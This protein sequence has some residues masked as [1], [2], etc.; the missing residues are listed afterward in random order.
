VSTHRSVWLATA[1]QPS[2]PPLDRHV[3]VDVVVV[4]GGITGL[5]TALFAQREGARVAVVE[6]DRIGGGTT[7]HTTGKVTSQHS[8]TYHGLIEKH[9][10]HRARLYAEANEAA[11]GMV[12]ALAE[13]TGADCQFERVPSFLYAESTEQIDDIVTEHA[14]AARL[15]L[16]ASLAPQ[17]DAPF[18]ALLG[19]RFDDQAHF[20]P[21]RYTTALARA[22]VDGGGHVFEGSRVTSVEEASDHAV[23]H[24]ADGQV[25]ADH[26]VL[27]TLLPF[28]DLGGFFAKSRPKRAYGIAARLTDE[29]PPGMHINAGSPTR[30]TRPWLHDGDR[31]GIIV[32]GESHETGHSDPTP[33]NWA[34]LERWTLEHYDVESFEYHWSAQDYTTADQIPYVGRSPR[35]SRTFV[36]TGF[37]KW[38]LTNGTAAARMLVDLIGGR[39]NPWLEAFDATRI[40][41]AGT[42]AKLVEDNVHVGRRFAEDWIGRLGAGS[43]AD[44][45]PGEGRMVRNGLRTVG[46]YRHTDGT[47]HAV[48]VTCT[49]LGCTVQWNAAETSWDCPCH[50][51]RFS[52]D[53]SVV[54]G[55]AVRPLPR[56]EI[57]PGK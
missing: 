31:R 15:G 22:V 57:D 50:G 18:P 49:H 55:P 28:V 53:G 21:T 9:G 27:A 41:D 38:G 10:E 52:Y 35:M 56:V 3:E 2:H 4:G 11:I 54:N 29:M 37:K 42:V 1:E 12:A 47:L 44:L 34:E 33:D 14:A 45:V 46:A 8:S 24:A 26:V 17:V 16:P 5:T 36:A 30:S 20:H 19:L 39:D 51:S 32:V 40:G 23:V 25:R 48:S 43:V 6:A 7:G 13:E